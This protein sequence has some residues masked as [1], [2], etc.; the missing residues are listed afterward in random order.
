MEEGLLSPRE[1]GSKSRL[2]RFLEPLSSTPWS[3]NPDKQPIRYSGRRTATALR[4]P[5]GVKK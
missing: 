5:F 3:A 4:H 1:R 2:L